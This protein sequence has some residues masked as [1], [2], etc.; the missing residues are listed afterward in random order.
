MLN[1]QM[2][3]MLKYFI[4]ILFLLFISIGVSQEDDPS[5]AQLKDSI[6]YKQKYGLRVGIDL[7][8]PLLSFLIDDYT[9]FEIVGDY[10]LTEDL[11]LAVELGNEEKTQNE[12][13]EQSVLYDYTTSGSYIKLGVDKN[14]YQNWFGMNNQITIGARYAYSSFSQTL[15]NFSYF[16]SNRFFSPDGFVVGSIEPTEFKNLNASWLEFVLGLKAE[17]F[18]NTYIGISARLARLVSN[19][20]PE[21]FRNLWIPGFNKVTDESKWGVGFNYSLSYFLPLYKKSKKKRKKPVNET[22]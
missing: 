18:T 10:R 14:T 7:S 21:N 20:D 1:D 4:N 15:N 11:Y 16:D 22:E 9:G 19:N 8:R 3:Y 2:Q 13:V 17:V 12:N 6:E 5:D